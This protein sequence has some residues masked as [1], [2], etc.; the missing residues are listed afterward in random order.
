M[1][2]LNKFGPLLQIFKKFPNVYGCVEQSKK[3]NRI[4]HNVNI[5]FTYV[6]KIT[7][8][9]IKTPF[10]LRFAY[11]YN[12]VNVISFPLFQSDLLKELPVLL[13]FFFNHQSFNLIMMNQLVIQFLHFFG[14]SV[15]F[16][17]QIAV[18]QFLVSTGFLC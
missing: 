3:F 11:C 16:C 1:Q 7:Q 17:A 2:F 5:R 14:Y 18:K 13:V 4:T 9:L 6:L 8:I 10:C 15:T 12:K